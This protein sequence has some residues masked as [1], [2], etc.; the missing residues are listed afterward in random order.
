VDRKSLGG[1]AIRKEVSVFF[2]GKKDGPRMDLLIY[3]P[4]DAR[5]ACAGLTAAGGRLIIAG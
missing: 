4:A 5:A 3:L 1:K 2:T